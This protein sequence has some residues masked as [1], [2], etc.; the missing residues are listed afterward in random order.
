MR[1]ELLLTARR[2][3]EGSAPSASRKGLHVP[4]GTTFCAARQADIAFQLFTERDLVGSE[5]RTSVDQV[6]FTEEV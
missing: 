5:K 2:Q 6:S 3:V 4:P 1:K